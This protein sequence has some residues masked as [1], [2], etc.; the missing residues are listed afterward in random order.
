MKVVAARR[1]VLDLSESLLNEDG[2]QVSG[3]V[4]VTGGAV[5][6]DDERLLPL[7]S[8]FLTKHAKEESLSITSVETYGKNL[9]YAHQYLKARRE[10]ATTSSDEAF[11]EVSG[12]L[13][14]EYISH[15]IENE[16]L[17]TKTVR[18][19]DATLLSFYDSYLC[20][21]TF[22]G[23]VLRED[24][25][26]EK[27]LISPSPKKNL[28]IPCSLLELETLI[29]SSDCERERCVLQFIFDAGI[30]RSELPRVTLAAVK[31]ALDAQRYEYISS[32]DVPPLNTD[33]C[34]LKIAG[35]K[36]R[37]NQEKPRYT[38]VSRATLQRVQRYHASVLYRKHA[39]K[40]KNDDSTPA[41]LN[42]HGD[43]Y[44]ANSVSKLLERL[45]ARAIKACK[46]KKPISPHKL[47]HG[48]AY[49]I[50]KSPDLGED[51]AERLFIAQK[52]M[53]HADITTTQVYTMVPFD[54]Y[55]RINGSMEDTAT[56]AQS[57]QALSDATRLK[58]GLGD[59]K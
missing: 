46:L 23:P 52:T 50:L 39:R 7:C 38:L 56:K 16:E 15:L 24:N 41:F 45:S 21:P 35:S 58:I 25:P 10:F 2:A 36:G 9:G 27:G 6:D 20:V 19:R 59:S 3:L 37:S 40:F 33:Y 1:V 55:S 54:I 48:Y 47:R 30:R 12:S 5:F 4:N 34:S 42:A 32:G 17:S 51:F 13:L 11:L 28:V 31:K 22:R 49:A 57:M 14:A 26:Y 8:G 18:N 43:T 44:T 29:T 53:G